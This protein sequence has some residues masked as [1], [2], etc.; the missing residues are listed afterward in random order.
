MQL[1]AGSLPFTQPARYTPACAISW[2]YFRH[3]QFKMFRGSNGLC[4]Q[5]EDD[6]S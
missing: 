2:R 3:S 1:L 6:M 5:P 4:T